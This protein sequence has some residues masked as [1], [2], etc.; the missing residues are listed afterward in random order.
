MINNAKKRITARKRR[1]IHARKTVNGTAARPRLSVRRSHKAIY[2]Q[3]IDDV[4]G[5]TLFAADSSKLGGGET[6]EELDGKCAVAYQVGRALAETAKAE[7]VESAV[8]DRS[9]YLYHGRV[10]AL[11]KGARD[12]GLKF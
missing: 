6:P 12:G 5:R 3:L 1:R 7:G 9:G 4:A 10:A 11:A 2:A 8:F